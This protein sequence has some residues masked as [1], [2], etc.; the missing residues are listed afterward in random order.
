[1]QNVTK[2]ITIRSVCGYS[3]KENDIIVAGFAED[4]DGSG[5]TMIIQRELCAE[6][7]WAGDPDTMDY[8]SNS[9]CITLGSGEAVYGQLERVCFSGAQGSFNFSDY[10]ADILGLG[11]PFVLNFEVPEQ[12]LRS[13]QETLLRIVKWG[14]PSQIP[15]FIGFN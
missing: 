8:F 7:P 10:A 11:R 3:D 9:Y 4:L 5:V 14:V 1:M 15:E 12:E 2:I 6:D 13:F